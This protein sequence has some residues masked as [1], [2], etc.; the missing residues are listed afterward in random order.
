M[1]HRLTFDAWVHLLPQISLWIFLSVFLLATVRILLTPKK[2][3]NHLESLPLE[4]ENIVPNERK[5]E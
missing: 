3:V 2:T 5:S 4:P 1:F